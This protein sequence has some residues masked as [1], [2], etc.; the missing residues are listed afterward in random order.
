MAA[1][2]GVVAS[3]T[4]VVGVAIT[5]SKKLYETIVSYKSADNDLKEL[6]DEVHTIRSIL[7]ALEAS[8]KRTPESSTSGNLQKCLRDFKPTMESLSQLCDEIKA[9]VITGTMAVRDKLKFL[10]K[11]KA[12]LAYKYRLSSYKLTINIIMGLILLIKS[13]DD[14]KVIEDLQNNIATALGKITGQ[15]EGMQISVQPII[16]VDEAAH[17]ATAPNETNTV[18]YELGQCLKVSQSALDAAPSKAKYSIGELELFDEARQ[19]VA[20]TEGKP[21]LVGTARAHNSSVQTITDV[22]L[23]SE[24][25]MNLISPAF[26][27]AR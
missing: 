17:N 8:L 23:P 10:F 19:F 18:I 9:K 11:E 1:E 16:P 2:I 5:S 20:I 26:K 12:F 14:K 22:A 3:I 13:N 15:I 27:G 4:T 6:S 25:L 7:E 21:G 24:F